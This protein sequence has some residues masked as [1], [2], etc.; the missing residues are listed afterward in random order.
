MRSF[1]GG[2]AAAGMVAMAG[3]AFAAPA[4]APGSGEI[5]VTAQLREQKPIDVPIAVSTLSGDQ[6]D[7]LGLKEFDEASRFIPGFAVQNQSPNNPAFVIRGITSDSGSAF[8]EP[9]VS[10]FQDGVS[11]SK[12]RGSYVE[13]LDMERVE[14]AKGPQSTLYGR[15]ALIGAVNLV[16][17][18]AD[19]SGFAGSASG[20]YGNF[21]AWTAEAMLNAPLGDGVAVRVAG[22][23]RKGDGYVA[24]LLGGKAL[25]SDDTKAGRA[26]LRVTT[27]GL[28]FDLIGNYQRDR[29]SGTPFK[30][31][32][33]RPTDPI[34]GAVLGTAART[35]AV[36]LAAAPGFEG[37]KGLGLDREVWGVTGIGTLEL[38]GG[39][40]LTSISAYR[41]F[42]SLEI[43]DADGLSLPVLTA[44]EN[45]RGRQTSQ[46]FRLR[47]ELGP[48]TAFVG[49]SYFHESGSQRVPAEFDERM[50]LARLTNAL[51]GGG[52][53]PGRLAT[54]PA[55][56]ALFNSTAF[57]GQLL[58]AVAAAAG[59]AL[60]AAQARA[61]AANLVP[62][63]LESSTNFSRTTSFDLFGDATY[64]VS[65]RF[66]LGAGLRWSHDDKTSSF[67]SAS[68][69]GR[70][71]LGAF[72]GALGQP[73]ATRTALLGALAVPGAA[74]IPVSPAY[75]VPWFAL[76]A[77]P[78][79]G[80]GS[81][82]SATRNSSR[83]VWRLTARYAPDDRTSLYA[84]YARGLRPAV[85]T[86]SA[87][88][89][90]YGAVRFSALPSERVDS[91]E[92]GAK[93]ELVDRTLFVDGALFYYQYDNF[94]T[95]VQQGTLFVQANAGKARSYGFEG[96]LRWVPSELLTL[97]AAYAYNHSRFA[98]GAY[99]GN[100]F[101]LS[102]DNAASIGAIASTALGRGRISFVPSITYQSKIWFDDN[103]DRPDLQQ[104]S[105]GAIVP[106]TVQD[107]VQGGYALVNA[108]LGYAFANGLQIEGFVQNV[109]NRKY[110]KDAGNAGD[111]FGLPT[112]I[113]GEPRFY[114]VRMS[115]R[116]GGKG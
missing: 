111:A 55:P 90:P 37:G 3:P 44:A 60:P 83:F 13:L 54:D 102:P 115:F 24:N 89:A 107:E 104:L 91:Y 88:A 11:I 84:T 7:R 53:I 21:D 1:V 116:F 40:S 18:K 31:I 52:T 10:V 47:Y 85:L 4:D 64:K 98:S 63:H 49:G 33:Y 17:N 93:A 103:N 9:R 99:D 70:S 81:V 97:F 42:S 6:L 87:P 57:T 56:A 110:V 75:P 112:F 32:A 12:S 41:R 80:N 36:A 22:R 68:L 59:T 109:F 58:Q 71:V 74:T 15:A 38:G 67:T 16:Q 69:N 51:N 77:Q 114:G 94:Q 73:A 20:S 35:S 26:S 14:V 100:H 48:L 29:T 96:D 25:G 28:T 92:V 50:A 45:A 34:T 108:R 8:S 46:E 76:G 65:E 27:G 78:T 43:L 39:F 82:E 2:V 19:P 62:N 72:L 101:R 66:E 105:S 86:A 79:A 30:S 23:I 95:T 106:D 5:V 61:I 113:A